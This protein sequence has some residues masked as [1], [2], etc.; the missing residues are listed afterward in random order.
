M[1]DL[2]VAAF[3]MSI[4]SAEKE[5]NLKKV[6]KEIQRKEF[7][8]VDLWIL[9]ELF[10]TGFTYSLFSKIAERK[11]DSKTINFLE[12]LSQ[13]YT[14]GIAGSHLIVEN[15]NKYYNLGF[16]IS[17]SKG[18]VYQ[19]KKI[20]LWGIEKDYFVAGQEIPK[21][22]NFENK[23][24]IGLSICYDLRFPEVS[25]NL[26]VNGA[27]VLITTS[28]WPGVRIEHFNLL[29]SARALEN[30]CFHI[31]LTRTG[32]EEDIIKTIYPGSSRII[33]PM[34]EVIAKADKKEQVLTA[35][36]KAE[37]LAETR[38]YIP[39]LKDRKGKF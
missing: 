7:S 20:H 19:Y 16:I 24:K 25:R 33:D 21:P 32:E 28:A 31:A 13:E 4:I 1:K 30:T 18:L 39:V 2:S 5:K 10:T 38:E 6:E 34:G 8:N 22:I 23:A 9:P 12:I 35:I 15:E 37:K 26:V 14:I 11:F 36:L 29:A 3:Q 17:P 27:E